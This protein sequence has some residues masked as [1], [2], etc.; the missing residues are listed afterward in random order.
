MNLD[1]YA[2]RLTDLLYETLAEAGVETLTTKQRA[3]L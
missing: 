1:H 3:R 2:A